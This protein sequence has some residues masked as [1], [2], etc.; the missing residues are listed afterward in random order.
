MAS[1]RVMTAAYGQRRRVEEKRIYGT[2][3]VQ[4]SS[5]LNRLIVDVNSGKGENSFKLKTNELIAFKNKVGKT[6][7]LAGRT[8][9]KYALEI[10][11][12]AYG[13]PLPILTEKIITDADVEALGIQTISRE[14]REQGLKEVVTAPASFIDDMRKE[15]LVGTQA[16]ES[17]AA[18]A[19]RLKEK[20]QYQKMWQAKRISQTETTR[21][22]NN[23]ALEGYKQSTVAKGKRWSPYL[24]G[25]AHRSFHVEQIVDID[26]SFIVNG[27]SLQYPGD[28]AG[29]AWNTVNCKCALIPVIR[30][31]EV[32]APTSEKPE[33]LTRGHLPKKDIKDVKEILINDFGG[34]ITD[35]H[36]DEI[37]GSVRAYTTTDFADIRRLQRNAPEILNY[38][39]SYKVKL[40]QDA[41]NIEEFIK[42]SPKYNGEVFRG[43]TTFGKDVDAIFPNGSIVKM[44]GTSSWS[45]DSDI[46]KSFG[47][48]VLFKIN[49]KSGVSVDYISGYKKAEK[50]VLFSENTNFKIIEKKIV[51]IEY[52]TASGIMRGKQYLIEAV[53]L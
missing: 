34:K 21:A 39:E 8:G 20:G 49:S 7:E 35:K 50:E 17:V 53:E 32:T 46:A 16:G 24:M 9:F 6:I 31:P 25:T 3:Y 19:S 33:R 13:K 2:C 38:K 40:K 52:P 37:I 44:G 47:N 10:T 45:S 23:G 26:E 12:I 51:E 11:E 4:L 48:K 36:A 28:R 42:K 29:S 41:T 30:R 22:F 43:I 1:A 5:I 27:E 18:I 15:F 14:I